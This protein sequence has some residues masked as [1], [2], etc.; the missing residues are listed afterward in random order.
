MLF[1]NIQQDDF[2]HGCLQVL[3]V[4]KSFSYFVCK[5]LPETAK[6]K[7]LSAFSTKTAIGET[8]S[9]VII[10]KKIGNFALFLLSESKA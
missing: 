5:E 7:S 3:K 9:T 4:L 8:Q 6:Q 2:Y 10:N 1:T